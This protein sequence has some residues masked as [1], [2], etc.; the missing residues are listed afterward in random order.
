MK[1]ILLISALALTAQKGY[2][3]LSIAPEAG[4]QFANAAT[5]DTALLGSADAITA[6]RVG[7]N[8]GLGLTSFLDLHVGAFY[9]AKGAKS[10]DFG[11]TSKVNL[12]YIEIPV[13]L[14]FTIG[15][16]TKNYFFVGAGPYL[17]YCSAAKVSLKGSL[18]G[19]TIDNE[20][21]LN[22]GGDKSTDVI[23]SM[24]FGANANI[25]FVTK[26]GLYARAHYALGL[27][28]VLTAGDSENYIKNRTY[29]VSVGYMIKL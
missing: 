10:E 2:S 8:V 14:N 1:K 21:D 12:N 17:A 9:S 15:D 4:I 24:D 26:F 7:V 23:E 28:N 13:Y 29:G 25:G 5:K 20:R 19:I 3:Q 27:A 18:P 22:V 11:F 16:K 6:Y